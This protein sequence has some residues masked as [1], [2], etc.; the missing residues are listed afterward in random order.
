MRGWCIRSCALALALLALAAAPAAAVWTE[1]GNPVSTDIYDQE[2]HVVVPDGAGGMI[3]VWAWYEN[4][5][6]YLKHDL[7]AQRID[8]RG[9]ELWADG[10][11]AVCDYT[12]EQ[13][14]PCAVSDGAGGV[15]V[16]WYDLRGG[17][18]T[19]IYAQRVRADG[20]VA[21]TADGVA[22]CTAARNQGY[23]A[24]AADGFGGAIVV[25]QDDRNA[26]GWDVYA[27]RVRADGSVAWTADGVALCT[28]TSFQEDIAIVGY[29]PAGAVAVWE[30][31]RPYTETDLYGQH[32][33]SSGAV[34]WGADGYAL[35]NAANNQY[36]PVLLPHGY[37]DYGYFLVWA[38][39]RSGSQTDIYAGRF[40]GVN[41]QWG[42]PNGL[43]V[44]AA[45]GSQY[46]PEVAPC[47][48][49]DLVVW[50]RDNR[51]IDE[52]LYAQRVDW[53]GNMLWT[54]DGEAICARAR[55][56]YT[57]EA[58]ETAAGEFLFVWADDR[59]LYADLYA[60]KVDAAG[61]PL[62]DA[63]GIPFV[64]DTYT[65][66]SPLL[67]ADGE[68]GTLVAWIDQRDW[69]TQGMDIYALRLDGF[70]VWGYPAPAIAGVDDV[71]DDQGGR[72]TL[73]WAASPLDRF[74]DETITHY[75]VW[76]SLTAP[77]AMALSGGNPA[78]TPLSAIGPD[79][80]GTAWR[81]APIGAAAAAWEWIGNV[82][83][84]RFE[85]YA[86]SA[87]TLYD[88]TNAN[89]GVHHFLVAAHA[90]DPFVW[91]DS[92]PDSGWSVD[93][94]AP[95][96][97]VGL[98]GEQLHGPEAL[99]VHWNP[100]AEEDLAGYRVYRGANA[101]FAPGAGNMIASTPDTAATDDGWT[102]DAGFWYKVTALDV[103]GNES[104]VAL[105][106]P[107][108]VTGGETPPAPADFLARNYPN[109]FNPATTILFGIARPGRVRVGVYDTAGRLVRL[110]L[111]ERRDAG[112]HEVAWDGRGDDGRSAASGV[113]FCRL[114]AGPFEETRKMVLL[115]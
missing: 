71:P 9:N 40:S 48:Q 59:N 86:M 42:T 84:H 106:G 31:A 15:I 46:Y 115:R 102:W 66:H 8:K 11:V 107:G 70:G 16:A 68:G 24:I 98:A 50:W 79:F 47:G 96:P 108:N 28:N 97:P 49:Y 103:H 113:Y 112:R 88:S 10:G 13:G 38:D 21:W 52:D 22:L 3:V 61:V 27:Q 92:E 99:Y 1:G 63:G 110:L 56:Q 78:E 101:E 25:W 75:S 72:V 53:F 104:P 111:D 6:G 37:D 87:A 93:N 94:L 89:G 44:C 34:Q 19:D 5:G 45:T 67:A 105:L 14:Y 91:W 26:T 62:W 23:P 74:P 39:A 57:A 35:V 100:N 32:V 83:A 76:R 65:R 73:T 17:S 90:A 4:E 85:E 81:T 58:I 12:D 69:Q 18:Y 64:D 77:A 95:E 33:D 2:Q 82:E 29:G 109:P 54:A 7:Y 20:S 80:A 36:D 114:V 60:Q 41:C 43:A 51:G 30:D 55:N